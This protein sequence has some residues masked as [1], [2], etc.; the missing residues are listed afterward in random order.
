MKKETIMYIV[1]TLLLVIIG[2]GVTYIIM[3]KKNNN[4][5]NIKDQN[6]DNKEENNNDNQISDGVKFK[7]INR[8]DD[9]IVETFEVI[10][11]GKK[12]D[13]AITYKYEKD[14]LYFDGQINEITGYVNSYGINSFEYSTSEY[15]NFSWNS[16]ATLNKIKSEFAEDNFIIFKAEDNKNYLLVQSVNICAGGCFDASDLYVYNDELELI[17]K[18]IVALTY[19][20]TETID[21]FIIDSFNYN[22]PCEFNGQN[23]LYPNT[24]KNIQPSI[25]INEGKFTKIEGDKIYFLAPI[26][27][28]NL[29]G[30]ILEERIYTIKDSKLSYTVNKTYQIT[31]ICQ[32]I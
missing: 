31:G 18:N 9:K 23:P 3:N 32:Q 2:V 15:P 6:K 11:N 14:N 21:A 13:F 24:F 12:K 10:L 25:T 5:T 26:L 22:I 4:N 29:T 1:I 16:E 27:N 17:S 30:G 7:S 19:E 20:P 28:D 8:E